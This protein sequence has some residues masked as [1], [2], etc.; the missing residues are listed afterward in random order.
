MRLLDLGIEEIIRYSVEVLTTTMEY[1]GRVYVDI[2]RHWQWLNVIGVGLNVLS[3]N[4]IIKEL[5]L[6]SMTGFGD[7]KAQSPN[8]ICVLLTVDL[9]S[10]PAYL[11]NT[12]ID[13]SESSLMLKFKLCRH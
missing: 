5:S 11:Q 8:R 4:L 1:Q 7:T 6:S 2:R 9:D 3:L 13:K 10:A 12:S